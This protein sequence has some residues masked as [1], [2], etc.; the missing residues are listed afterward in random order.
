MLQVLNSWKDGAAKAAIVAFVRSVTEPGPGFVPPSERIATFDNDGTLWCEKPMYVQADFVFRRWA[1]MLRANPALAAEQPYKAIAEHDQGWLSGLETHIPE[2]LKG[3]GEAYGGITVAEF[4]AAVASFFAEATHPTLGRPYTQL[5]YRPMIELLDHLRAH[6]FRVFICTGG[7]R[8]FVRPVAE[9][10]YGIPRENVIGSASML[11][12]RDGE[13]YRTAGVELPID[14][15]PGKPVHIFAR[16]GRRPLLAGGNSDGDVA[17][18]ETARFGLLVHHDDPDREFAY[19]RGAE[20][21]LV[22]ARNRGWTVVSMKDDFTT[23]F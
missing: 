9:A 11:E 6:D 12:Y 14:D 5:G 4:E 13:L 21:A 20:Q 19:D 17:M 3:V 23:V 8:D 2:L 7:G 1:E 22:R 16:T 10:M 18:L 15:G